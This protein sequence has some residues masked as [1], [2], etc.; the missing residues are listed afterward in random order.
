M[1]KTFERAD[2]DPET[3][4]TGE[5]V[6][7]RVRLGAVNASVQ[8]DEVTFGKIVR[9]NVFTYFNLIFLII[10][11]CLLA[12]RSYKD[13]SFVVVIAANTLIGIFQEWQSKKTLDQLNIVTV[14]KSTVIRD[15]HRYILKSEDLVPDDIIV[16]TAG[17]QIPAD[18][19]VKEGEV[20]VNESLL[21]GE[22][23][24]ITKNRRSSAVRQFY[25][26]RQLQDAD[27][28]GWKRFILSWADTAG[29]GKKER[30]TV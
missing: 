19:V 10:A 17:S 11:I 28:Q 21:T 5:Q 7:E 13:L 24:E 14:P 4:L 16:L 26:L 1:P 30:G 23:D 27:R 25:R 9:E 20:S 15:G 22:E 18:A 2:P 6:K 12:V 8:K 29:Q 3:G